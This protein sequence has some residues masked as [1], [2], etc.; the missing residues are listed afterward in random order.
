MRA[1]DSAFV[2]KYDTPFRGHEKWR[3]RN[4]TIVGQ[5]HSLCL[6]ANVPVKIWNKSRKVRAIL[7]AVLGN[8]RFRE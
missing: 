3:Q 1:L 7:D 8:V 4:L 2:V 5:G 6:V